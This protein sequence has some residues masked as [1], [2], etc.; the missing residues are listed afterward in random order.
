MVK[1]DKMPASESD[2]VA[3]PKIVRLFLV[4]Q[5]LG[6]GHRIVEA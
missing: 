4:C 6:S 3:M 1:D 5:R 2:P